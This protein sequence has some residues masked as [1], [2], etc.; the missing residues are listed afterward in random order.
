LLKPGRKSPAAFLASLGEAERGA[1]L[2]GLS[3]NALAA[4]P[5]LWEVWAHPQ[6]QLEPDGDWQTWVILGGRGAGKTRAGAEWIRDQVEGALPL[7][8]GR[9]RRVALVGETIDQVRAVM[10]EG[11]S[12]LLASAPPD[13]RPELKSSLNKLIWPNGAEAMLVSA[14]NPEALRG[15]QYDCA[16][17]DETGCPAVDLGANQPN[18][19]SDAKS[20]ESALPHGSL[21]VRDDEMQRRFLQAKLGYWSD[22]ANVPV[23]SQTGLPMIPEDRIFVWTWDARPWPDFP[24]RE[25]VWADGPAHRLGHWVSG[26]VSSS[27]LAEVVAEICARSGV[28]EIN[29]AGL[30]GAVDGYVIERNST[31]RDALQPLMLAYGFDAFESGGK[32]V[33]RMR[34]G[35]TDLTLL[36]ESLVAPNGSVGTPLERSRASLGAAHDVVRLSYVQAESDFRVGASE[37][38]LPGGTSERIADTSLPLALPGSKAQ[39]LVE[40]WLAESWR[41]RDRAGFTLAP[42]EVAVEPGD[43]VEI[44]R[45]GTLEAYRIERIVDAAGREAEAVRVD[46]ALHLP[47]VTPERNVETDLANPPGPVTAVF[48]D[49]PLATGGPDDH[50]PRVAVTA[51]PWTD[52]ITVYRSVADDAYGLVSTLAKPAVIGL[53]LDVLPSGEPNRWQRA[54]VRIATQT[55]GLE[56]ADR[57]RVLNSANLAALEFAPG[58]WEILQFRDASLV[59]PGEYQLSNLLRG[60]RGT[61][62]I[63]QGEIAAG[64]RFVLLDDAVVSLPMT[65]EERGLPRHYRVGPSRYAPS[66]PSYVHSIETFTGVGLRPHAPA[67]LSARRDAATGDLSVGWIRTG[68]YGSD[69]WQSVEIPLTEGSEAYRLRI[70]GGGVVLRE[71]T[72]AT[73]GFVYT[74]A[75]QAADAPGATLELRIAQL[76]TSFGYGPERVLITDE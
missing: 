14:A 66:H 18:L 17:S 9:S 27:A 63:S 71:V 29:V 24:V 46:T 37:A 62:A 42:S 28:S 21:G 65:P 6:H 41:S 32:V 75:M 57:L 43:T 49:L 4:M 45:D 76:S 70:F 52:R 2:D 55:G 50:Q 15:P 67:H 64:A 23:S 73:P 26:R 25:S 1:F 60:L 12:G 38:R 61:D 33:F 20:S 44:D 3:E 36:E 48:L 59:A 56:A 35:G 40:R 54:S 22:T 10:V 69:S 8:L 74:A 39:Q 72:M 13:R 51:N 16:W 11:D 68:R 5:W 58:E 7:S 34:G 30:F 53:T 47:N 19:F 31:A